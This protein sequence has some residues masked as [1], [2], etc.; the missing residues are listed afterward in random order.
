MDKHILI[1]L[2]K[3]LVRS[4]LDYGSVIYG[5]GAQTTLKKLDC[6]QN[7]ALRIALGA[8]KTTPAISLG[9]EANIES[10]QLRRMSLMLKYHGR[11][12]TYPDHPMVTYTNISYSEEL[13]SPIKKGPI[14]NRLKTSTEALRIP[15]LQ[16]QSTNRRDIP[17]WKTDKPNICLSNHNSNK[18]EIQPYLLRAQCIAHKQMHNGIEIYTDGSKNN[19]N[20]SASVYIPAAHNRSS[21]HKLPENIS[22]FSAETY[23]IIQALK[24]IEQMQEDEFIIYTDSK[25]S[26]QA[27]ENLDHPHAHIRK[28]QESNRRLKLTGKSITLCWVPSHTNIPGNEKADEMA[29]EALGLTHTEEIPIS[30]TEYYCLIHTHIKTYWQEKWQ[31]EQGNKLREIKPEIKNSRPRRVLEIPRYIETM[32]TRLRTGHTKLTHNYLLAN[33]PQ[34]TCITCNVS[35]TVRHMLTECKHNEPLRRDI[36]KTNVLKE[37]LEKPDPTANLLEFLRRDGIINRI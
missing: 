33:D 2:Y 28:I 37:I 1:L 13:L 12:S 18:R 8:F 21:M 36:L 20:S 16:L 9:I 27:L 4:K 3:T 25:S 22:I 35:L 5:S 34:P 17:Y 24:A 11:I 32:Y 30:L 31:A 14:G 15:Q 6:I 19:T 26:L 29:K 10:L 23:A 7:E